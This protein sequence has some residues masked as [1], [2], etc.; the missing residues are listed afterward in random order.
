MPPPSA[1]HTRP[2]KPISATSQGSS[3]QCRRGVSSNWQAIRLGKDSSGQSYGG[4]P[5]YGAY[6]GNGPLA[7][8]SQFS[9]DSLWEMRVV[10]TSAI[11]VGTALVG[12]FGQGAA[13]FGKGGLRVEASNSHAAGSTSASPMTRW[14]S[15]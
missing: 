9:A 7:S 14:C 13:S 1:S 11:P 10:V 3:A 2:G 6:G 4:G 5:C 15:R 8:S 12:A